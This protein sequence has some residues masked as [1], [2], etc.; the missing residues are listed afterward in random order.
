VHLSAVDSD[1]HSKAA[2]EMNMLG[3]IGSAKTGDKIYQMFFKL[4][5]DLAGV[6]ISKA[7]M[8]A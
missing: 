5:A 7:Q 8:E 2:L 1:S 6:K 4:A 3:Y